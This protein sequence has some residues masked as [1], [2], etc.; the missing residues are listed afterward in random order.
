MVADIDYGDDDDWKSLLLF[1]FDQ[2][3]PLYFCDFRRVRAAEREVCVLEHSLLHWMRFLLC[4]LH[5]H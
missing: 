5:S 3:A 4:R 2:E 1:D